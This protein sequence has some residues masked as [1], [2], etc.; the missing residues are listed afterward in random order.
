MRDEKSKFWLLNYIWIIKLKFILKLYDYF[1]KNYILILTI[2]IK[3]NGK[4]LFLSFLK[5]IIFSL[6]MLSI[7][8]IYSQYKKNFILIF[9]CYIG[10]SIIF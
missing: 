6:N 10:K 1:K 2:Y 3:F 5:L 9:Y 4:Y 7:I 8:F